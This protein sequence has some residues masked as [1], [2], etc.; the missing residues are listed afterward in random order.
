M[1]ARILVIEDNLTNLD[2]MTYLLTAFGHVPLPAHDGEEGLYAAAHE[3]PDLII[4]DLQLPGM[5]GY[6]VARW[7]KGHPELHAIPLVAVTALA[8]VGDRDRVLA[9]GF[10]GYIAKPITPETFVEQIER[11]LEHGS[12]SWSWAYAQSSERAAPAPVRQATLLVVDN[13]PVHIELVRSTF[14]PFGYVVIA[15]SGMLD[16]LVCARQAPPDLILSHINLPS[17]A[18]YGLI[19]AVKTDPR[20]CTIPF[21]LITS[22]YLDPQ[23]QAQALELGAARLISYPIEPRELLAVI[24]ACLADRP[25]DQHGNDLDSRR[26]PA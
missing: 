15:V 25:K 11:F 16:A 24:E 10:D 5:D 20:L 19:Q 23:E 18:S 2:L 12:G 22:T 21:V 8:M 1:S 26:P 4:C 17:D 3:H 7:L 14:E 6:E 13:V 9:A